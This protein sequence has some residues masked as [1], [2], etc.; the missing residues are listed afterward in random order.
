MRF[1]SELKLP[2]SRACG[3]G[4]RVLLNSILI[5]PKRPFGALCDR[6]SRLMSS[7][8]NLQILCQYS[9]MIMQ[10]KRSMIMRLM[11]LTQELGHNF[12]LKQSFFCCIILVRSHF[13]YWLLGVYYRVTAANYSAAQFQ[14]VI[15]KKRNE[16]DYS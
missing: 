11:G 8:F 7:I 10:G 6:Q 1:H 15:T 13:C 9:R 3:C 2:F 14:R 5:R 16:N 4:G 12:I